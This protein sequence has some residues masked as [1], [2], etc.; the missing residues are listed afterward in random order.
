MPW[1]MSKAIF[2]NSHFKNPEAPRGSVACKDGTA[3]LGHSPL[4]L[5]LLEGSVRRRAQ[6]PG[7]CE[8]RLKE[9]G[10]CMP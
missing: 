9:A 2:T 8:L 10:A 5:D 1:S 7:L 4:L 6:V 3:G